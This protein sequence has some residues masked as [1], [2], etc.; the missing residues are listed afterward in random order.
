MIVLIGVHELLFNRSTHLW[1]QIY[2]EVSIEDLSI[3][4]VRDVFIILDSPFGLYYY[5]LFCLH[6]PLLK[7]RCPTAFLFFWGDAHTQRERKRETTFFVIW[8]Q[9]KRFES[10]KRNKIIIIIIIIIQESKK[11]KKN[12]KLRLKEQKNPLHI[13]ANLEIHP[14]NNVN[15]NLSTQVIL[16][17]L[18]GSIYLESC[19]I[20]IYNQLS[21]I[22]IWSPPIPLPT[23]REIG[24]NNN[25][26]LA[27][28]LQ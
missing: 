20:I 24:E 16:H 18:F 11:K 23:D 26:Q 6:P 7:F 14:N 10:R 22:L 8:K 9:R 28:W 2:Q 19:W 17:P 21:Y 13:F 27:S 25:H 3:C 15:F 12:K 1:N 4:F 5:F